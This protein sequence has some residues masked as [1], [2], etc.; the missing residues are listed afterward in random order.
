MDIGIATLSDFQPVRPDGTHHT[1][2]ERIRQILAQAELADSVG[3]DHIGVGEHHTPDFAVASPAVLLAAIAARTTRLRL[4]T[5]VS[6]LSV[7]DP[8]RLFQDFA[9]LDL[10]SGG[11]AELTVGRSAFPDPFALFGYSL[12]HY[13]E[14]FAE[15]LQLLLELRRTEHVTWT[16][17]HRPPIPGMDIPPRPVQD[18]LP[19]WIGVGGSPESA[20]RAGHLGLPMTVGYLGGT[21]QQLRV[22]ADTYHAAGQAA[23]LADRL[24]LGVAL[25]YFTAPTHAEAAATYPY[26][27]DFLRPKRP[28][29]PGF[30]V[31]PDAFH[32]G[33]SP[34]QA[35]MIGTPDAVT[36]KL[37]KLR[38]A[39]NFD[40]LQVLAD[41]GGLPT[42][43]V[44]ESINAL[45]TY[46]APKLRASA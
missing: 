35:L 5:A 7:H 20:R 3:L 22:L 19:V 44:S 14:L 1:V 27:H 45:G 32:H 25:H 34:N 30:V 23:G 33:M 8:V 2:E 29:S 9:T 15:K 39:V 42:K 26:Y 12:D 37:L 6:L 21:P 24:R 17:R 11:R 38:N 10:I 40:R 4:T 18:P 13:D 36:E 46:I 43:A 41:W 16:G 28:G 31:T